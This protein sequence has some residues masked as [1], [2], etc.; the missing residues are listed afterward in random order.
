[1][2]EHTNKFQG[3]YDVNFIHLLAIHTLIKK[4]QLYCKYDTGSKSIPYH[5]ITIQF[6]P[7]YILTKKIH[8]VKKDFECFYATYIALFRII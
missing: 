5:N 6:T 4:T 2:I 7:C 8:Y 3:K 1:M